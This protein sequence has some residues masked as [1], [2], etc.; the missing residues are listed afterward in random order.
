MLLVGIDAVLSVLLAVLLLVA[1]ILVF[2][3]SP[4][5]R[6]LHR[7]YAWAKLP[8]ALAGAV[9]VGWM[10]DSFMTAFAPRPPPGQPGPSMMFWTWTIGATVLSCA[11][12]IGL[13][14]AL[15]SRTVRAYYNSIS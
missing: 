10:F 2:R 14:I 11:Y 1:G 8:L 12:S 13:L 9:G 6:R 5:S 3:R 4:A 7:I 15:R